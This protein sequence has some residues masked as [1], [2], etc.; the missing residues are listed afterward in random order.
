M[1]SAVPYEIWLSDEMNKIC[2][3]VPFK[4]EYDEPELIFWISCV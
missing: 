2:L 1:L 3:G 4:E